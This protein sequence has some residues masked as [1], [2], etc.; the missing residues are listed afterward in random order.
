MKGFKQNTR[1]NASPDESHWTS[2][3]RDMSSQSSKPWRLFESSPQWTLTLLLIAVGLV[4]FFVLIGDYGLWSRYKQHQ[5]I[6]KVIAENDALEKKARLLEEE[7]HALKT[8]PRYIEMVAREELGLVK[9][10]ELIYQE[11]SH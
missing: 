9:K 11:H 4:V 10:S 1:G 8:D 3:S 7:I 5:H 2:P 6:E